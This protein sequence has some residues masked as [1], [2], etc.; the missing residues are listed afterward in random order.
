MKSVPSM[1]CI[2]SFHFDI[3]W[4]GPGEC[5]S[6]YHEVKLIGAKQN[7]DFF[8]IAYTSKINHDIIYI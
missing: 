2:Q 8:V 7:Q 1:E 3:T 5:N 6:F 4:I